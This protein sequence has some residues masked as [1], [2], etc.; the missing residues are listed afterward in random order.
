MFS[1][2]K[3]RPRRDLITVYSFIKGGSRGGG[4][5]LSLV[6][7]DRMQG[8]EMKLHQGNFRL[9]ISKRFFTERVDG[10]WNRVPREVVAAPSLSEFTEHLDN[11]L[12][13]MV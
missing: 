1:L 12:S 11:T 6:T 3:R 8:N 4:A 2:E 5:N 10:H 9:N 7:S 13:H